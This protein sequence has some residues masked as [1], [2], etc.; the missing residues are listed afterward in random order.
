MYDSEVGECV[1][2]VL[3]DRGTGECVMKVQQKGRTSQV[4][5]ED[6]GCLRGEFLFEAKVAKKS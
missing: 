4:C 5:D 1:M 2:K 6:M 3:Y